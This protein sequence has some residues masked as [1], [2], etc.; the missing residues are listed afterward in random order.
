MHRTAII[1][2]FEGGSQK[3]YY[4]ILGDWRTYD[5]SYLDFIDSESVRKQI[6]DQLTSENQVDKSVFIAAIKNN[7]NFINLTVN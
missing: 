3:Q 7:V 5:D 4:L 2:G 1:L 6:S